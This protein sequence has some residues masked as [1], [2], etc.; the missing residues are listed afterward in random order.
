[1]LITLIGALTLTFFLTQVIPGDAAIMKVGQ[2]ADPTA[3]ANMRKLMGLDEPLHRQYLI[4]LKNILRGELGHSWKTGNEVVEDLKIRLPATLELVFWAML[5]SFFLGLVWG[6][7]SAFRKGGVADI[8]A[9]IFGI[10]GGAIPIFWLALMGVYVF[11]FLLHI[12]PA[13]T[14]RLGIL[15]EPPSPITG[16]YVLD[17]LLEGDFDLLLKSLHY[18]ILPVL[19]LDILLIPPISRMVYTSVLNVLSSNY[20]RTAKAYGLSE[21][22][23]RY[24]YALRN[25]LIP[26]ITLCGQLFAHLI[27]GIVLVEVVFAWNGIGRYAVNS[28]QVADLAPVRAFILVVIVCSL[29]V[30]FI[31]DLIYFYLD[32]RIKG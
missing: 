17:S 23:I 7:V 28:L 9:Q 4:Y 22:L 1:M 13:P 3:I 2:F 30:N 27:G 25:A 8:A 24:R 10:V 20:I 6:V 12:T 31:I 14:G 29:L 15:D 19:C 16:F 11:Y 5:S 32:P 26:V 18:L 21:R